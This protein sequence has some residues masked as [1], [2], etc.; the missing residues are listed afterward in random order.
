MEG[1][2][3]Y[4]GEIATFVLPLTTAAALIFDGSS[5]ARTIATSTSHT[6]SL[7]MTGLKIA[8]LDPLISIFVSGDASCSPTNFDFEIPPFGSLPAAAERMRYGAAMK[9]YICAAS[10]TPNAKVTVMR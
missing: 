10:G 2:Q 6:P 1:L 8:N 5:A 3:P 7:Y 4:S 9:L